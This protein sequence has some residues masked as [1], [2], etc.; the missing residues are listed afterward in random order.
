MKNALF[1]I[2]IV[3][4]CLVGVVLTN[5]SHKVEVNNPAYAEKISSS[6]NNTFVV[7]PI[8]V[9]LCGGSHSIYPALSILG[10]QPG[11]KRVLF[12]SFGKDAERYTEIACLVQD[13]IDSKKGET[14]TVSGEEKNGRYYITFVEVS[15][16][17]FEF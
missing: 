12:S 8:S 13:V 1:P 14:I 3:V 2:F 16:F 9:K 4:I 10:E 6:L 7:K 17:K 15:G 11:N 5:N